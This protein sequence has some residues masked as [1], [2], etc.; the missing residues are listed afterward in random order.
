MT[1]VAIIQR[2]PVLLDR[3]ATIAR[4]VQSVAEAAAAGASLIVL[5]ESYIPG[6]PSWI[7]RLAA[8]KDGAVMGQLHTRLLA[9]AV[10]ISNGD[11][12][13][14]CEAAR[15]HAVTIVCGINECERRNG[16]GTLY[17][18]VVVIGSNGEVLNR[19]RKLMPTNPERMVHG[20]GDASGLRTVDTPVGRVGA[21]IC[22]ENYMP[23]ARYSLYAQGVEIYVAPTYDT[24]EGWI[25]TMRHIALEGRCWVL[26]SGSVLRGSDI[27]DDF[28]AR[29]QLFPDL[30]EWINDGDSVVVSPQG[31]VVAGPLHKEAGILYAD[32]DVSLVAPAR[33]AL[34]VTGHYARPDIFELQVR[35]TPT[36]AVRYIDE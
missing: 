34:D 13:E 1:K 12:S 9:N 10:D 5:P 16:G 3:S 28:P 27:P 18:S 22:W 7:W 19:H 24:G 35:R 20:F 4:A 31:R 2:P 25:S 26:G 17:N 36:T 33:R 21:L 11:L 15:V 23:L 6:Y 8:G 30:E 14:L 29:A 32:I